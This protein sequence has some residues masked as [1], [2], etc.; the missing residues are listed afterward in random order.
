MQEDPK[1]PE[2]RPIPHELEHIAI[3]TVTLEICNGDKRKRVVAA[4]DACANSTNIDADLAKE[5][6]LPVLKSGMKRRM[7][8][9]NREV[10]VDSDF[11][12]F[13]LSPL[14]SNKGFQLQGF[15]VKNLMKGTPV[16]D[17]NRAAAEYAHLQKAKIPTPHPSDRVQILIGTDFVELMG[18]REVRLGKMG[19][20]APMAELTPLGWAFSGRSGIR[21]HRGSANFGECSLIHQILMTLAQDQPEERAVEGNVLARVPSIESLGPDL[22]A[23]LVASREYSSDDADFSSE[24]EQTSDAEQDRDFID[25][26]FAAQAT[27]VRVPEVQGPDKI[28]PL[29]KRKF[30]QEVAA[31]AEATDI[32][33]EV[34]GTPK[35]N[36]LDSGMVLETSINPADTDVS[37]QTESEELNALQNLTE[38]SDSEDNSLSRKE[39]D[40]ALDELLQKQWEME[41]IGLAERAPRLTNLKDPDPKKW[42]QAEVELDAKMPVVYIEKDQQ[43]QVS[44]PWKGNGPNFT[45][46]RAAVEKRQENTLS[47]LK[48]RHVELRKIFDGYLEKGYIRKL[49]PEEKYEENCRYL[50][51]FCV[52]DESKE[53]T[54]VR[55]VWDFRAKYHGKSLNSE[56]ELTPNRLQSLF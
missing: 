37:S 25:T 35:E 44:I 34:F 39:A 48:S 1:K 38:I 54:P 43:F 23:D 21:P 3:R 16:I 4:L 42:T 28:L 31:C 12:E 13:T 49:R 14:D 32:E 17:W 26:P 22:E 53:T 6:G 11:V 29:K 10:V 45:S 52:V 5:L 7:H 51:F 50:P 33:E 46:N 40:E 27:Q 9:M 18:P 55:I 47:K 30:I 36:F 41:A 20:G 2:D 56:I 15:T 19:S 8:L 24:P